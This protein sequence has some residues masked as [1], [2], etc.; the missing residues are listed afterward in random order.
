MKSRIIK[1]QHETILIY[2]FDEIRTKAFKRIG[3]D[4]GLD[5]RTIP[6]ASACETVGYLAGFDGFTS[7]EE[8]CSDDRQ[9]VIF[10]CIDGKKLNKILEKMRSL[11]LDSIPLKA[12]VTAYNQKMTLSELMDELSA[13]HSNFHS[14]KSE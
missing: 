8:H 13:E 6:T 1:T 9:C 14:G 5:I 4:L 7:A 10:S 12:T 3:N 11:G 2:G